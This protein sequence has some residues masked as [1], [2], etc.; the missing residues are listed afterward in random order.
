MARRVCRRPGGPLAGR[1]QALTGQIGH[2]GSRGIAEM[3]DKY[4]LELRPYPRWA[5]RWYFVRRRWQQVARLGSPD[6][7]QAR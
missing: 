4:L 6:H 7:W 5:C 2:T 3:A 1:E